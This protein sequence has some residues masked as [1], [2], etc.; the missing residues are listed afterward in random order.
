MAAAGI[1]FLPDIRTGKI[2]TATAPIAVK[3]QILIMFTI[4]TDTGLG[5]FVAITLYTK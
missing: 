1:V 2:L 4:A 5:T 3:Y